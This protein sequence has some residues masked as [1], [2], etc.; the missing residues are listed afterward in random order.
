M[1]NQIQ[2]AIAQ[3]NRYGKDGD[4]N[5]ITTAKTL[6]QDAISEKS[7]N[8]T[9]QVNNRPNNKNPK[10][11]RK[12]FKPRYRRNWRLVLLKA[13]EKSGM[14]QRELAQKSGIKNESQISKYTRGFHKP[15]SKNL[16]RLCEALNISPSKLVR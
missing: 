5:R 4:I 16:H 13:I 9:I 12:G 15:Y 8:K 7:D 2:E 6:L 14:T 3:L 1:K 10:T 11:R